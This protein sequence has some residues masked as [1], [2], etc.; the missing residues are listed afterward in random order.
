[1]FVC[2][3]ETNSAEVDATPVTARFVE[4]ALVVVELIAVKPTI[5]ATLAVSVSTTPV[6]KWPSAENRLVDVAF[7]VEA[8]IEKRLV[9]VALV[10]VEFVAV[11]PWTMRQAWKP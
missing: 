3:P 10:V 7:V 4:V 2:V 8:F 9:L 6:V 11:N 1:M 5:F